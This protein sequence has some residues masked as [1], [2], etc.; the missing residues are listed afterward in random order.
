MF[1]HDTHLPQVLAPDDYVSREQFDRERERL[2][3][4]AW[5]LVGTLADLPRAGDYFT[6]ELFDH[7]LLV[8][9]TGENVQAFLNVC[10][11]R[12]SRI[13]G[14]ACGHAAERLKCQYHGWEFDAAGT[15]RKIPDARSFRPM[16]QGEL[17]LVPFRTEVCGQLI[18]VNLS[19]HAPPLREFLGSGYELAAELCSTRLA[20]TFSLDIEIAANW[21]CKIENSLESYHIEMVHRET[22]RKS[23]EAENSFHE[24]HDGWSSYG[25]PE[26]APTARERFFDGLL[27]RLVSIPVEKTYKHW[28]YFPHLMFGKMR[29]FSWAEMILPLSPTRARIRTHYFCYRG[30]GGWKSR[31]LVPLLKRWQKAFFTKV[32]YEDANV[33]PEVQRGL[34]APRRPS[35]GLISIREERCW[36]FQQHVARATRDRGAATNG[37]HKACANEECRSPNVESM[38]NDEVRMTKE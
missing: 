4:P 31:L 33:L 9:R 38:T 23:S 13:S 1:L 36:H 14:A 25:T 15:T 22:F 7:P 19:E 34:A 26:E 35:A 16:A 29:L 8:W 10:P 32:S 2:F 37:R 18:F 11:H 27:E 20:A 5:H 12:F 6:F 24:L 3:L 28:L 17:G 30:R 21:K